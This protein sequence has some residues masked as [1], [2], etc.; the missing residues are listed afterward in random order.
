MKLKDIIH[1]ITG[2][3]ELYFEG[4]RIIKVELPNEIQWIEENINWCLEQRIRQIDTDKPIV[5]IEL[6]K[7]GW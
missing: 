3:A 1:L 5:S 6:A 4:E 7:K 2:N